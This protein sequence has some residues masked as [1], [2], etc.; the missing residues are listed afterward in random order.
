[1]GKSF[2]WLLFSIAD[3]ETAIPRCLWASDDVFHCNKSA[4]V[5]CYYGNGWSDD[6]IL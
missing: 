3:D 6:K 5:Y 2:R 1:M 4:H